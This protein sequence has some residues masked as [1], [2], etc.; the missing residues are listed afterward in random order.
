MRLLYNK[1]WPKKTPSHQSPDFY[2]ILAS[3]V[4]GRFEGNVGIFEY[5]P[6]IIPEKS[7]CIRILTRLLLRNIK[8][9]LGLNLLLALPKYI[10]E[11]AYTIIP[12]K[13]GRLKKTFGMVGKWNHFLE[14]ASH[15]FFFSHAPCRL[16]RRLWVDGEAWLVAIV[17]RVWELWREG[18]G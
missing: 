3:R 7:C 4:V 12:L 15:I 17:S 8:W 2:G 14:S 16:K 9:N 6:N 5:N 1:K 18:Y 13:V 10:W 11:Y